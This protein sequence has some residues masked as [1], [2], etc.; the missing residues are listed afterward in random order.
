MSDT[1][2]TPLEQASTIATLWRLGIAW[3]CHRICN[4]GQCTSRTVTLLGDTGRLA[5]AAHLTQQVL[6][7]VPS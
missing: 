4:C 3:R 5:E 1:T 2:P 6:G 7:G